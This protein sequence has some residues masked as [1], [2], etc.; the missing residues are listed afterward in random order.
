MPMRPHGENAPRRAHITGT[1][2][3]W[4]CTVGT[5]TLLAV[6]PVLSG[7]HGIVAPG[8]PGPNRNTPGPPLPH[9]APVPRFG[10]SPSPGPG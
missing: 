9:P 2:L 10:P 3:V 8:S 4:L 7:E 1:L 5:L 6:A